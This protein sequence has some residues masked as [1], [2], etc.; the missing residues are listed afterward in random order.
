MYFSNI[1]LLCLISLIALINTQD[2]FEPDY[3]EV[4]KLSLLFYEA[5]RSGHLP[6]TNRISWRGDSALNDKGNNGED[7]SG[8]YYD[9]N[10]FFMQLIKT[11]FK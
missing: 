8:G 1:T 6:P 11:I 4:I 10:K 9:G 2:N 3:G 7:L 5:Q